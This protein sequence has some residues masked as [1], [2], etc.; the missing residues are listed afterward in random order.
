MAEPSTPLKIELELA[1]VDRDVSE[2]LVVKT[3]RHPSETGERVWLR[4]LAFAWQWRPGL[5][6]LGSVSDPDAPDLAA[7]DATGRTSAIVLVGK[8]E[9]RRLLKI[10]SRAPGAAA[11]IL[12]ET[13]DRL[14][15]FRRACEVEGVVERVADVDC[16]AVEPDLL[17]ALAR[18]DDRRMR[19]TL[20]LS[21]DT[22][23]LAK[24]GEDLSGALK[25]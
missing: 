13:P 12:F 20:T 8:P 10:M 1:N 2:Q 16:A 24:D 7:S 25:R 17:G 15:A 5:E 3:A 18:W 6:L 23:Y 14:A 4:L 19:V 9:V 11:A 21:G 22:F